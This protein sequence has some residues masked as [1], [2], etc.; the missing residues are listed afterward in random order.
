MERETGVGVVFVRS[1]LPLRKLLAA[2]EP[3][4]KAFM[5]EEPLAFDAPF[6]DWLLTSFSRGL[7]VGVEDVVPEVPQSA[8]AHGSI[9]VTEKNA[10]VPIAMICPAVFI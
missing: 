10:A 5:P 4:S 1:E 8:K 6:K 2:P 3:D 7:A 9:M